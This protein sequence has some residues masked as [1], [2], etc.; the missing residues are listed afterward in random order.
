MTD[1]EIR[2]DYEEEVLWQEQQE[3]L[4]KQDREAELDKLPSC[5]ACDYRGEPFP[6]T[7]MCPQ[8][9]NQMQIG[10]IYVDDGYDEYIKEKG[11][12]IG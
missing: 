4:R 5:V 6:K 1:R 12:K 11:L 3:I 7:N 2:I 10:E 9:G 8:C